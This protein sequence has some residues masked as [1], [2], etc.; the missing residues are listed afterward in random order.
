MTSNIFGIVMSIGTMVYLTYLAIGAIFLLGIGTF[1]DLDKFSFVKRI[2][3]ANI[4]TLFLLLSTWP[5][6]IIYILI[7]T[8]TKLII[9]L[10]GGNNGAL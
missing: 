6:L 10:V 1:I 2:Y 5:I 7:K 4:P 3:S 9:K 8:F